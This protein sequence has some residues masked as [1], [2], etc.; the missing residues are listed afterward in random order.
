MQPEILW[1]FGD[2]YVDPQYRATNDFLVY[3]ERL[4]QNFLVKNFAI[5]GTGPEWSLQK[6][7]DED[8]K[9]DNELK[10]KI[11][12]V[13][14]ASSYFRFNFEFL[15]P[16]HQIFTLLTRKQKKRLV[17]A[18]QYKHWNTF[19]WVFLEKYALHN[20]ID[21]DYLLSNMLLVKHFAMQYNRCIYW[22]I[23]DDLESGIKE[24]Y[25]DKNFYIPDKMLKLFAGKEPDLI[26]TLP[27]HMDEE[28]HNQV[29][30]ILKS[31]LMD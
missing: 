7:I 25:K 21:N 24:T 11:G 4:E 10:G 12:I 17:F 14:C 30:E 27:N 20:A 22:P 9:T 3:Y 1:L 8:K 28:G 2:S 19:V 31:K 16:R 18:K 6:F 23:F 29:Y 26:Y 5:K 15:K 13:F